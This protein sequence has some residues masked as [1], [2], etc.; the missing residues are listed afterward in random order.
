MA[1]VGVAERLP[2]RPKERDGAFDVAAVGVHPGHDEAA[3]DEDVPV[4]TGLAQHV[5]GLDYGLVV[6]ERPLAV[7][8]DRVLV[9]GPGEIVERPKLPG[10]LS[11]AAEA[12]E[13]ETV[14]LP[15]RP[16]VRCQAG[17]NA[18]L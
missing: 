9:E 7:G 10:R 4:H 6:T 18:Q 13:R 5:P 17:E 2:T 16:D 1:L 14:Q 3:L 12:V 8:D 11:P 15:D